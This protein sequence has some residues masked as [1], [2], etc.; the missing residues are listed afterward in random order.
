MIPRC[1]QK[2]GNCNASERMI[3]DMHN[4]VCRAE[5]PTPILY[6]MQQAPI[7][8]RPNV[9][10]MQPI[11]VA[12]FPVMDKDKGWC[13]QWAPKLENAAGSV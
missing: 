12:H 8:L 2:C 7:A 3:G 1:D 9:Q 11:I 13:R 5:P 4:V 10:Q 6:G